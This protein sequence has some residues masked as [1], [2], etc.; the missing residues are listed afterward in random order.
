[1]LR[2]QPLTGTRRLLRRVRDMMAGDASAQ[3]R[4]D[5]IVSIIAADMV[6]EVCSVYLL[7][8]GEVLEL[9][10]TTGLNPQAVHLTRLQ[11]GEG[12]IGTIAAQGR[13][14]ADSNVQQNPSFVFRPETGEEIYNSM[15]GVPVIRG[16]RVLG[17][18]AVQNRTRRQYTEE[19]FE[20][21]ETVAMVLAELLAGGELISRD[22]LLAADSDALE[23]RTIDGV[24]LNGGLG[25]GTAV[26]HERHLPIDRFVAE[27]TNAERRRLDRA[28]VEMHGAIDEMIEA[29]DVADDGEHREVL[30]TYRMIA[31][32]AGWLSRIREAIG[33]GLTAEAAVQKVHNETRVRLSAHSDRYIR[34][35]L[36]DFDDLANRLLQHLLGRVGQKA[37]GDQPNDMIVVARNMGPAELLDYDRSKLRGLVLEEGSATTHVAIIARA[38]DVPVVG[39]VA[40]VLEIVN[41]GDALVVDGDNAQVYVRPAED[42]H[43]S[44]AEILSTRAQQRAAY[45]ALRDKPAETVDGVTMSLHLNAGLIADMQTLQDSGADGVGLYRTEI[46]FMER[47][48]FPDVNQQAELYERIFDLAGGKPV[49]FRTLDVG[50][51]KRLPYWNIGV[52]ENPALG[53]RALR[54]ALDRPAMLRH[55]IRALIRA[56]KGRDLAIM[57]PMVAE[58]AEFD[59]AQALLRREVEAARKIGRTLPA[60]IEVGTM[61]EVPALAFQMPSLLQRADFVSVGSNDLFQF[62]FAS[63]RG[64]PRLADRYDPLSPG[65]LSFL[66]HLVEQCDGAGVPISLCGEMAGRPLDAMALVGIGFR[67][68]S[69]APS[70]IGPVKAMIRSLS[71]ASL[72]QYMESLFNQPEHSVREKLREFAVDHGVKI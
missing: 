23:P 60:K 27:D 21:L 8:A 6:A 11:L 7:R 19:E 35:R 39:R 26:M 64:N 42:L 63:D 58:T 40:N 18:L 12:L 29:T 54:V 62:L 38:L 24:R 48:E 68:L 49:V 66:K 22:E 31:A 71:Q 67:R 51:D 69:M 5:R 65:A 72:T 52:E 9:F 14:I 55:Q 61:L 41:E 50:S 13:G 28:V 56:A 33:T 37:S 70:A 10:A 3:D 15:L 1:M 17:V 59:A 43:A 57:F 36:H 47:R 25:M 2:T 16:G 45:A 46:P 44:Y 32:D 53:W 34:E 30:E 20:T 4:L